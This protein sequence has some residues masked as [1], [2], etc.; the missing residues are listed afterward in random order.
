MV[1]FDSRKRD[2]ARIHTL[3]KQLGMS[4]D[5]ASALKLQLTGQA[6]SADM[7]DAQRQKVANHLQGLAA[8]LTGAKPPAARHN[9]LSGPSALMWSL[10]QQCADAKVVN[11]RRYTALESFA[12]GHTGVTK[13]EWLS[14][15]QQ[16][17]VIEALKSMK[18]RGAA[19]V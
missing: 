16:T 6:S 19:R 14:K 13:L 9:R 8:R 10:W 5:D 7:T 12:K 17:L 18:Q 2:L 1:K 4:A 3:Q 15:P 11:D